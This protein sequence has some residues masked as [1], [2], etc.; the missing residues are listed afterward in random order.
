MIATIPVLWP[1]L[2]RH[3]F[4]DIFLKSSDNGNPRK[5][6]VW[7]NGKLLYYS[8]SRGNALFITASPSSTMFVTLF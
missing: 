7:I 6:F 3:F 5:I 4:D 1:D 8:L 2:N